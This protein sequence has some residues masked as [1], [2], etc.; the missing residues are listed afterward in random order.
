MPG[1]AGGYGGCR[2]LR[3]LPGA[4]GGCRGLP[5]VAGAA[6]GC[7]GCRGLPGAVGWPTDRSTAGSSVV[8]V[9]SD[10][11]GDWAGCDWPA[12][13]SHTWCRPWCAATSP[14]PHHWCWCSAVL[15][16]RLQRGTGRVGHTGTVAGAGERQALRW[17]AAYSYLNDSRTKHNT[18]PH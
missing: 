2:G 16:C 3:G 4:A 1:A 11:P 14:P 15:D 17:T 13:P 8:L 12:S 18:K 9:P 5:G 6:W 7:G 10:I